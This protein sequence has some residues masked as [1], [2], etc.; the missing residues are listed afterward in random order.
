MLIVLL[1]FSCSLG[2]NDISRKSKTTGFNL[3]QSLI[4]NGYEKIPLKKLISGHL[5]LNMKL[6][7]INGGFILDTGAGATVIESKRKD[8]F[9]MVVEQTDETA[10]GA[11]GTNLQMQ[12]S[13]ENEIF[14]ESVHLTKY[15]LTL[16][17]LDHVNQAFASIGI[18]EVDGVIG[19]DI[20]EDK[21]AVIDYKNLI[22]YLKK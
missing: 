12:I 8:K 11:G 21:K 18:E 16:M 2:K 7:S 22:L 10:T 13:K 5:Y 4:N 15:E 19:A 9:K 14:I 6:N 1:H 3:E 17:N 20:L